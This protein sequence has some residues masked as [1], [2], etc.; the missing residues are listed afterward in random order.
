MFAR[1]EV[2]LLEAV[3]REARFGQVG[4]VDVERVVEAFEHVVGAFHAGFAEVFAVGDGLAPEGL[5][6]ADEGVARG[7]PPVVGL[8]GRRRVGRHP[9]R[10]IQ[11]PEV[12]LPAEVVQLGVPDFV[13]VI[14][15]RRRIP[16]VQHRIQRHLVRDL[17]L[18]AVPGQDAERRGQSA[19]RA[20]PADED[21]VGPDPELGSVF[22]HPDQRRVAVLDGRRVG[23]L[24]RQPVPR[25][26]DHRPIL[27]DQFLGPSDPLGHRLHP[28][29]IPA[30][31][32]PQDPRPELRILPLSPPLGAP[33]F[34][35][36]LRIV[37]VLFAIDLAELPLEL[38]LLAARLLLFGRQD[39]DPHLLVLGTGNPIRARPHLRTG[40]DRQT[41]HQADYG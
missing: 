8:A 2:V 7:Q 38:P 15:G 6:R 29:D 34:A 17:H 4:L 24:V 20:L 32:Q 11:H 18:L 23:V 21:L 33:L 10:A 35:L 19:S 1:I 12:F 22:D 14:G 37:F 3:G 5:A 16:V 27:L 9:G 25:R 30:A 28:G 13:V 39:Q 31:V 40:S 36:R 26:H 41:H